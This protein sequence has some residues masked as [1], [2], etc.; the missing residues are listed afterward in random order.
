VTLPAFN[1]QEVREAAHEM[2]SLG[3][4]FKGS[5]RRGHPKFEHVDHGVMSLALTP[6]NPAMWIRSH[7]ARLARQMG[8]ETSEL[9]R[10]LGLRREKRNPDRVRR[11]RND[12]GRQARTFHHFR[13]AVDAP[14]P[15]SRVGTP[16]ERRQEIAEEIGAVNVG[17]KK[18]E[19]EGETETD[20]YAWLL[21][22]LHGLRAEYCQSEI[23]EKAAA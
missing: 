5:G 15:P 13:A 9:Y 2:V 12:E 16:A 6:S 3:F 18:L 17:L 20:Q 22:E 14:V 10:R 1:V 19:L 11:E 23:D 8:I 7:R 21:D 4:E